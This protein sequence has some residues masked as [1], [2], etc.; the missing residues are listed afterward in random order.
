MTND[1]TQDAHANLSRSARPAAAPAARAAGESFAAHEGDAL[2]AVWTRKDGEAE[3]VEEVDHRAERARA[4]RH[5]RLLA[6]AFC[7]V[8][9]LGV[10]A[11]GVIMRQ[12]AHAHQVI[13]SINGQTLMQDA[14]YHLLESK[15]G[16]PTLQKMASDTLQQQYAQKL[17]VL[18]T[19]AAVEAR[20][21]VISSRPNFGAYLTQNHMSIED[22]KDGLKTEMAVNAIIAKTVDLTDADAQAYYEK[23]VA[24]KTVTSRYY[25]PPTVKI[26]ILSAHTEAQCRKALQALAQGMSFAEAASKYS[27]DESKNRGGALAPIA[28][29]NPLYSKL[30]GFE[31]LVFHMDVGQQIGP[32]QIGPLW[33]ILRCQDKQPAD[34]KPFD[35]VAYECRADAA[36]AKL[37]PAQR[38]TL[39]ANYDKFHDEAK[40]SVF[41]GQYK[42][43]L[44]GK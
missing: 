7:G 35:T 36:L 34:T 14:F 2:A 44:G 16:V 8:F 22:A 18:P 12:R 19:S 23:Q 11:G 39:R 15:D 5:K 33:V 42:N 21:K 28:R 3:W 10:A 38:A 25:T 13:A 4:R 17:G 6:V 24:N 1:S 43:V 40:I 20:Y 41:W 29:G 26:A 32:R 37:S 30:P 9:A 31:D 27:I